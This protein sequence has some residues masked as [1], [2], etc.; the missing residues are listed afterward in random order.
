MTPSNCLGAKGQ[1]RPWFK[2]LFLTFGKYLK[3]VDEKDEK[4]DHP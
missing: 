2:S 3:A 1:K 4:I